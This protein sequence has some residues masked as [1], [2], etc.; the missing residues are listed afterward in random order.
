Q[1][2]RFREEPD[3]RDFYASV[4]SIFRD[5][6][7]RA[8]DPVLDALRKHALPTDTW[9]DIGAGAGRYALP[10]ARSVLRVIAIDPSTSMLGGLREGMAAHGIAN[11]EVVEGRWPSIVDENEAVAA[12]LPVDVALIAHVGYDIEA[13]GPF[14]DEMERA[15]SRECV[16]ILMERSPASIAEPF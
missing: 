13:I 10:L 12:A 7:D 4:S 6:P 5:D 3:G 2:D 9:L 15:S 16:A 11:V 14:L 1:V 8:G